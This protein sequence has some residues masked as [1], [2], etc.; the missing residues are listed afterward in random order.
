MGGEMFGDGGEEG[1]WWLER[2]VFG[3]G[4]EV[5]RYGKLEAKLLSIEKPKSLMVRYRY[6]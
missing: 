3:D 6:G 1:V 2:R 5:Y 4:G